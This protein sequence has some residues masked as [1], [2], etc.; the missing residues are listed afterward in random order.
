MTTMVI[1]RDAA[2]KVWRYGDPRRPISMMALQTNE[3]VESLR[4]PGE[5]ASAT[6][7]ARRVQLSG[8]THAESNLDVLSMLT[9][10]V[11]GADYSGCGDRTGAQKRRVRRVIGG[12]LSVSAIQRRDGA[13]S[14][15]GWLAC[16]M[17]CPR[18][19]A[20]R[21]KT[22]EHGSTIKGVRG[23]RS[24]GGN[25]RACDSGA[26]TRCGHAAIM[27]GPELSYGES[28]MTGT[29][30]CCQYNRRL[31]SN[32]RGNRSPTHACTTSAGV[33]MLA[34]RGM[35]KFKN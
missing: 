4:L 6:R 32:A 34:V 19:H 23:S 24:R 14:R 10:A 18:Y 30:T 35:M 28:P 33:V 2:S 7:S 9:G 17:Q 31:Y 27:R 12:H 16:L 5:C 1:A 20:T 21:R 22:P 8:G 25:R 29:T 26:G 13:L 15:G 3:R 11:S